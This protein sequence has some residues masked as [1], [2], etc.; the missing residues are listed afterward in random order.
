MNGVVKCSRC[1]KQM[2]DE[3]YLD[4]NCIPEI[5]SH[6][7]IQFTHYYISK[8]SNGNTTLNLTTKDGVWLECV[9]ISEDKERTKIPYQPTKNSDKNNRRLNR[10]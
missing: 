10:T 6:K 2:I 4:H 8:D 5:K 7:I 1:E 3:E 9:E